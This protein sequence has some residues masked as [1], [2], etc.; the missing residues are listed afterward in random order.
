[1]KTESEMN[2]INTDSRS[3]IKYFIGRIKNGRTGSSRT[4][5]EKGRAG[6]DTAASYLKKNGFSIIQRNFRWY[7]NEIDIVARDKKYIVFIEVK[8]S[9]SKNYDHPLMWIPEVKQKRIIRASEGYLV[10]HKIT[11]CPVRFDVLAIDRA[12]NISHIK[13]AFRA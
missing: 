6:E 5:V 2:P 11:V 4:S 7:G 10:S 13:D 12:G 1:M 9:S 8:A 3:L